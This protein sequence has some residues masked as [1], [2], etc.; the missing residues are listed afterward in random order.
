[1]KRGFTLVELSIVLVIIGLLISGLLVGQSLIESAKV[2]RLIREVDQYTIQIRLF[3][4]KFRYLPG[5][6]PN[7]VKIFG[8]TC[9]KPGA[10][11]FCDGN[12]NGQILSIGYGQA[13][14]VQR[15]FEHMYRGGV[16]QKSYL[17][18]EWWPSSRS[19]PVS[20]I[21][22]APSGVNSDIWEVSYFVTYPP[23]GNYGGGP[24]VNNPG[25][26]FTLRPSDYNTWNTSRGSI[27][28]SIGMAL[29]GKLDDGWPNTGDVRAY[30]PSALNNGT[31]ISCIKS[32]NPATYYTSY[33]DRGCNMY[34]KMSGF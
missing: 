7:F 26:C 31:L 25:N 21:S 3:K 11:T 33:A 15:V 23:H 4:N 30:N 8:N 27:E 22:K 17:A 9:D 16:T 5:D 18:E 34:I 24:A 20:S 14:D 19:N 28:P 13:M 12:G 32:A 29:D 10:N 6:F 2:Q 1:M